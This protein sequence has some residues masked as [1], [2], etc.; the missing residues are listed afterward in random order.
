[1]RALLQRVSRANVE[2]DQKIT[3]SIDN[4][5]LVFLGIGQ[6][7][8]E[9]SLEVL[10][11][12]ISKLRIFS[13]SQGKM[14][15]SVV[16]IK[17][18]ILLVSQFTLFADTSSGNRPSFTKAAPPAMAIPLYERAKAR[19]E[20]LGIP[21]ETGIFGADMKVALCNDGPV[22]IWLDTDAN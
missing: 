5:L 8:N 11:Q 13:D 7:D 18:K 6:N 17:G 22:T 9:K 2:V 21:T 15:L 1:M 16:D 10:V 14:N 12:K 3:G 4:G 19:F 20:A